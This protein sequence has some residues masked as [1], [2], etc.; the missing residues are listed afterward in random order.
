MQTGLPGGDTEPSSE[1]HDDR[2]EQ[3]GGDDCY[4]RVLFFM[5]SPLVYHMHAVTS[6]GAGEG[7]AREPGNSWT[8]G[9]Q[10]CWEKSSERR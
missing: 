5:P 9:P 7:G 4:N 8:G 3:R 2:C 6:G 10:V 1:E